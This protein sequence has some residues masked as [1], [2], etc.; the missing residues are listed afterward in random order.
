MCACAN[1]AATSASE[2]VAYANTRLSY[3][4]QSKITLRRSLDSMHPPAIFPL[5]F[6]GCTRALLLCA[7]VVHVYTWRVFIATH[8]PVPRTSTA[9]VVVDSG[10]AVCGGRRGM[11][12]AGAHDCVARGDGRQLC[13]E[14]E[15][16]GGGVAHGATC[17]SCAGACASPPTENGTS[18]NSAMFVG[19]DGYVWIAGRHVPASSVEGGAESEQGQNGYACGLS[20]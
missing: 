7:R 13:A 5:S 10:G 4:L 6:D 12:D 17:A 8:L 20:I 19:I 18:T 14:S 1:T 15:H 16:S 2:C 11:R 3:S 9:F